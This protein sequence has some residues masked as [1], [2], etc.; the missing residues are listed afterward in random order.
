MWRSQLSTC[1][2]PVCDARRNPFGVVTGAPLAAGR[3]RTLGDRTVTLAY[4]NQCKSVGNFNAELRNMRADFGGMA[5][6]PSTNS[7]VVRQ[8]LVRS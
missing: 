6:V 5:F 4:I 7:F 2:A 1:V 8:D 3:R